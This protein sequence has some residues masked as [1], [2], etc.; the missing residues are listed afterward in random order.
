M[1]AS[2]VITRGAD[3]S[4]GGRVYEYINF[5]WTAHTDGAVTSAATGNLSPP[6]SGYIDRMVLKPGSGVSGG[7]LSLLENGLPE[8]LATKTGFA[9]SGNGVAVDC[10]KTVAGQR[11]YI[12][13]SGAG[14]SKTGTCRVYIQ[15]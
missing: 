7:N 11:L 12:T 6:I 8:T 4:P 10:L 9:T 15:R 3:Q 1:A 13:V 14:E 2:V 5:A